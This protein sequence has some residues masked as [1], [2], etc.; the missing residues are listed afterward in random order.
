MWQRL[1]RAFTSRVSGETYRGIRAL[2]LPVDWALS[3]LAKRSFL[4]YR[5]WHRYGELTDPLFDGAPGDA[6]AAPNDWVE[7]LRSDGFLVAPARFAA[8]DVNATRDWLLRMCDHA[9]AEAHRRDPDGHSSASLA[10]EEGDIRFEAIRDD[11][12]F[13][14][15]FSPAALDRA[16]V[17]ALLREFA[18]APEIRALCRAY[19][20]AQ[21]LA[22]YLPYY[23]AEVM[24]P[25]ARLE[26]WHVDC[27]RPTIKTYLFL[28]TVGE[29]QAP[30]RYVRGSHRV[31]PEKHRQF[32]RIATSGLGS[33]YAEEADCNR[34][35]R[36]ASTITCPAGTLV[37]FDNRGEHAG[38]QCRSG[39]RVLLAMGYRPLAATRV[40]PRLFRDPAPE[41]YPWV[42]NPDARDTRYPSAR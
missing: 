12:R 35:D 34:F 41:P 37:V 42:R 3:L 15:H 25:A 40:N 10:W 14:F 18:L 28:E 1:G 22:D 32:F 9:Q 30:L 5:L 7:R 26:S 2:L 20:D 24:L 21:E 8:A 11:G 27:M 33:A 38:S 17:P 13:R 4:A 36:E 6:A 29:E 19:F 23:M 16:D 39:R 31:D